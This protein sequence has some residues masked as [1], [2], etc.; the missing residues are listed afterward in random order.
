MNY[1]GAPKGR[2]NRLMFINN[3]WK[4]TLNFRFV[5]DKIRFAW[6][7]EEIRPKIDIFVKPGLGTAGALQPFWFL[8]APNLWFG[9]LKYKYIL[10]ESL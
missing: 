4:E 7:V 9:S 10:F 5:Y 8:V 1:T 6:Q 2:S 3:L